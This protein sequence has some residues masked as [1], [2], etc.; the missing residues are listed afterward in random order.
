MSD[1]LHALQMC[2]DGNEANRDYL[3]RIKA[4]HNLKRYSMEVAT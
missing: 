2:V 4:H 1:V 3:H